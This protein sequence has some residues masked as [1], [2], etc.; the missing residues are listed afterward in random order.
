M[1]KIAIYEVIVQSIKD[2]DEVIW[3]FFKYIDSFPEET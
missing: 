2:K 3:T 1:F